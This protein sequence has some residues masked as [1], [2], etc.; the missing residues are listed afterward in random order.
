MS[1][2]DT[3]IADQRGLSVAD[4]LQAEM[5]RI[6]AKTLQKDGSRS[7][8]NGEGYPTG[9]DSIS[10]RFMPRR[11]CADGQLTPTQMTSTAVLH[12]RTDVRKASDES[13]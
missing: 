4:M 10:Y 13:C 6:A 12:G 11:S 2:G 5:D 8:E 3:I 1:Y 9:I 7:S